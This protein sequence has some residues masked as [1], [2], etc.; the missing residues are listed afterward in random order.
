MGTLPPNMAPHRELKKLE[1]N[2]LFWRLLGWTYQGHHCLQPFLRVPVQTGGQNPQKHGWCFFPLYA[3]QKRLEA[4]GK[5]AHRNFTLPT[6][7]APQRDMVPGSALQKAPSAGK[8]SGDFLGEEVPACVTWNPPR[9]NLYLAMG[10][11]THGDH[12]SGRVNI[13]LPPLMFTRTRGFDNHRKSEADPSP[14]A[15]R[16][17]AAPPL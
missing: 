7:F 5:G 9:R 13:H 3:C 4:R 12:I 17:Q 14:P 8:G 10:C 6:N 2:H 1:G 16:S 11:I 15:G